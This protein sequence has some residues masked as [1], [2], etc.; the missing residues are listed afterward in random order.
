MPNQ[1]T[2]LFM[3]GLQSP[4]A[5]PLES[6]KWNTCNNAAVQVPAQVQLHLMQCTW[7]GM[8]I[9]SAHTQVHIGAVPILLWA[10]REKSKNNQERYM[11]L[12][13]VT[14]SP[15]TKTCTHLTLK[16]WHNMPWWSHPHEMLFS[17]Q[18]LSQKLVTQ[19]P[20]YACKSICGSFTGTCLQEDKQ[21]NALQPV[22]ARRMN[23]HSAKT[24]YNSCAC[25][26]FTALG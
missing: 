19:T 2:L 11:L 17:G 16:E 6:C 14:H 9:Y 7:N 24:L 25:L 21:S 3:E 15:K 26:A 18:C 13:Q 12:Q 8:Y 4:R 1:I 22:L 5:L 20:F 10:P 23:V